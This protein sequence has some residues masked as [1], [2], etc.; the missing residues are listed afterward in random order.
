MIGLSSPGIPRN[1]QHVLFLRKR[2]DSQD[3][4]QPLDSEHCEAS[5]TLLQSASSCSAALTP[6]RVEAV[7]SDP[8][9][10]AKRASSV[11]SKDR[12][13]TFHNYFT[14]D[15]DLVY[16]SVTIGIADP[17]VV[18]RVKNDQVSALPWRNTAKSPFQFKCS[19]SVRSNPAYDLI[20][21]H[22]KLP[23][24]KGSNC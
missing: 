6:S 17:L 3:P 15:K 21:F 1:E 23:S 24:G 7:L 4:F 13:A 10:P 5:A 22:S 14:P 18:R 8:T 16:Q 9:V 19:G 11:A 2:S 12:S 20:T